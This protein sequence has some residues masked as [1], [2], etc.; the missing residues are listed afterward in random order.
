[1]TLAN[2]AIYIAL[3]VFVVARRMIGRPVGSPKKL[4]H[5]HT[6]AIFTVA[7]CAISKLGTR[8]RAEAVTRARDLSLLA[9]S[10]PGSWET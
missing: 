2:I 10:V 6:A 4:L 8:R 9:P 3:I 7:G 5:T 1:M